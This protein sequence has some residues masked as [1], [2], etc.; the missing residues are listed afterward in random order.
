M[1][2]MGDSLHGT[3]WSKC[4]ALKAIRSTRREPPQTE[5]SGPRAE[6][7]KKPMP[8]RPVEPVER[9]QTLS[10]KEKQEHTFVP[11]QPEIISSQLK[12]FFGYQKY[13]LLTPKM[14]SVFTFPNHWH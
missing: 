11:R 14:S 7:R 12:L 8:S 13:Q 3:R 10:P 2:I 1:C 9:W 6:A 4:H 5:L